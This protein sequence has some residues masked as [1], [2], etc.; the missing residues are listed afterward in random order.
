MASS[1]A[2]KTAATAILLTLAVEHLP[3]RLYGLWQDGIVTTLK[4]LATRLYLATPKG[5][6]QLEEGAEK[7]RAQLEA[8]LLCDLDSPM[9]TLPE[10]G[11]SHEEVL[12]KLRRMA[13]RDQSLYSTGK[14]SGGVYVK[15]EE[16]V[17]LQ[18]VMKRFI[19]SNQLHPEVFPSAR[20]LESEV[21]RM[22]VGLFHGDREACGVLTSGGTESLLMMVLA[23]REWGRAKGIRRPNIVT[24]LSTHPAVA[25]AGAYFGVKIKYVDLDPVTL[26]ANPK[27]M[28]QAI[29]CNT[30]AIIANAPS[31]PYGAIDSVTALGDIA[32]RKGVNLHVDCCLGGFLLPFMQEAGYSMP[33][34]DFRVKGVTSISCDPHKYG[35]T[36]KGVSVIMYRTGELRRYQF[37]SKLDWT[38]GLYCT[39]AIGGS[40]SGMLVA[41]AWS[42]IVAKGRAGYVAQTKAILACVQSILRRL[43][44]VPEIQVIGRPKA[45][46]IAFASSVV[47]I[48]TVAETMHKHSG[49]SLNSLQTPPA[50]H[51]CITAAN[52]HLADQFIVDLKEAVTITKAMPNQEKSDAAALYGM[53]ATV[54]DK[55]AISFVCDLY[56]ETLSK[57]EVDT[58]SNP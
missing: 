21:I 48:Y 35:C 14:V 51:I 26:E 38:G 13:D 47:N 43:P 15:Q 23:Y 10:A 40:R 3:G 44:E 42:V 58:G 50:V 30:V 56:L 6:K 49:W 27:A 2:W 36:P 16:L 46:I 57:S 4:K 28:E 24:P 55:T 19:L 17:F 34:F 18:E 37:F 52:C 7:A 32:V 11:L 41:A 25:K 33:D 39:P 12:T 53:I 8:S 20:Q 5:R 31:Y 1:D 29:T 45:S 22:V 9:Q 54:P